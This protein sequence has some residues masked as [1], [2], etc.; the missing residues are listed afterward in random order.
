MLLIKNGHI[1]PIVGQELEKGCVLIGDDGKI[2][3][4]GTDI[5][6]PE[7]TQVIDAEGRLVTPGCVEAHCHV[8]LGAEYLTNILSG[9]HNESVDPITPQMRAIDGIN[10]ADQ[11]FANALTGGVTTICTGPGSANVI[12]GTFAAVKTYGKRVDDMVVRFPVAMKCAFGENPKN[13]HGKNSKKTPKTRMAIASLLREQLGKAKSYVQNKDAGNTPAY[14]VKLE[15]LEP[16]IRKQIPLKVHAH[17]ADDIFT[18]IRIAKEF[19]LNITLDHCTDGSSIAEELAREGFPALV[20]PS[21]GK[22]S[23]EELQAK[24]FSTAGVLHRAGVK[25]SVISDANVTP[26]E[27][28][29]LFAGLAASEGLPMEAAWQAITINPAEAMGIADRVGS[30]EP[31][32][33][34]DVVIWT[35]DPLTT[36]GGRAHT[37]IINGK[38]AYQ[39]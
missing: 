17:R 38:V 20:G 34:G 5:T 8:G 15:A 33:D 9:E 7:G 14:D 31:G 4:V 29:P 28:L 1:R 24:S 6:A 37:T 25:V 16:V 36:I 13:A 19:D 12:G 27:Y 3:S 32:K 22:R 18:A 10:P 21:M 30:L 35:A 11:A 39:R 26:I 23:K 2:L